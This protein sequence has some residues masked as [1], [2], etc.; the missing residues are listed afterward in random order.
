MKLCSLGLLHS[1]GCRQELDGSSPGRPPVGGERPAAGSPPLGPSP[2][3][4]TRPRSA[5]APGRRGL[6]ARRRLEDAARGEEASEGRHESIGETTSARGGPDAPR[7]GRTPLGGWSRSRRHPRLRAGLVRCGSAFDDRVRPLH[8]RTDHRRHP[9]RGGVGGGDARQLRSLDVPGEACG[10]AR[11]PGV[12]AARHELVERALRRD[13]GPE[14]HRPQEPRSPRDRP[15]DPGLLSGSRG[16]PRRRSQGGR[17]RRVRGQARHRARQGRR[18]LAS[19]RAWCGRVGEG[20]V[21]VRVG[22]PP[23]RDR[24]RGRDG[25]AG[26]RRRLQRVRSS[27]ASAPTSKTRRSEGSSAPS[28]ITQRPGGRSASPTG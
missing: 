23:R 7:D 6:Y 9:R 28:S 25:Q 20:S 12:R 27:M 1:V 22:R 16:G 5:E 8:G 11:P 4:A 19:G 3:G 21:H 10:Q 18:R 26:R 2:P 13:G 14:R 17:R 15:G 24:S